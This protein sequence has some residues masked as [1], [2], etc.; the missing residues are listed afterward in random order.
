[1]NQPEYRSE[2]A[3]HRREPSRRK[4]ATHPLI[5]PRRP[6]SAC[7][8]AAFSL[9]A[10][11][12]LSS[13]RVSS[14]AT[15][16][17]AAENPS[18]QRPNFLVI[19]ADDM[20]FSDAG[21]YGGEIA[22]P[23]LDRL[24]ENGLRFTQFYSCGRCWPS[25]TALLTGYYPQQVRMDP[26]VDGPPPDWMRILPHYLKPLG[27]RSYHS[28]KWHLFN[29]PLVLADAGFDRSYIIRNQDRFFTP[30]QNRLDDQP[31]APPRK[32]LRLLHDHGDRTVRDRL[33]EAAPGEHST[34]PFC[35]YL[36]FTS[37][38]FPLHALQ[39][40]IDRYRDKYADGWDVARNRR[41]EALRRLGLVNSP[42][43]PYS[44]RPFPT[45]TCPRTSC[46]S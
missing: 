26:P 4:L 35:L 19:L 17:P 2:H 29:R 40:D 37:P 30:Q 13:P 42:L 5:G 34:E 39:E 20:G 3:R 10:L 6:G 12:L 1:M 44:P 32:G 21:C 22:T 14:G 45:G 18:A 16:L 38:H 43:P 11:L 31:L 33:P 15:G 9:L 36:A 24:A 25:R 41:Y 8:L 46:T 23:N 27:Y 7:R 28:G